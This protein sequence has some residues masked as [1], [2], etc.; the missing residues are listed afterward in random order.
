MTQKFEVGES[1][2]NVSTGSCHIQMRD[3]RGRIL[4]SASDNEPTDD[5]IAEVYADTESRFFY[6]ETLV[7]VKSVRGV[8]PVVVTE[9]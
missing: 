5:A 4:V 9:G 8:V 2:V 3:N 1:W 7:W 6:A